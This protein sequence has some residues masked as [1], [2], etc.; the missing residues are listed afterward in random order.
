MKTFELE[1]MQLEP[2]TS[3]ELREIDGGLILINLSILNGI[4]KAFKFLVGEAI[5]F[6]EGVGDGY[7]VV[8]N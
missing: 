8:V 6:V 1:Q 4:G 5:D 7:N 3:L 2:L